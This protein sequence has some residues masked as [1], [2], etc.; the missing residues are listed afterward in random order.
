[1]EAI[2]EALQQEAA[3]T[4]QAIQASFPDEP[5][6]TNA[7][8]G[9]GWWFCDAQGALQYH[10]IGEALDLELFFRGIPQHELYA[11]PPDEYTA[12]FRRLVSTPPPALPWTAFV[13][14]P[15]ITLPGVTA[16]FSFLSP[17]A[18]AYYLPAYLLTAIPGLTAMRLVTLRGENF[19]QHPELSSYLKVIDPTIQRLISPPEVAVWE[20]LRHVPPEVLDPRNRDIRGLSEADYFLRFAGQLTIPQRRAVGRFVAYLL[21]TYPFYT[22]PIHTTEQPLDCETQEEIDALRRCW[23]E[24]T[25]T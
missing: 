19:L 1:M 6:P 11:L 14:E 21:Q 23:V 18:S 4:T 8:I 7:P 2:Q 12:F 20:A 9:R 5:F 16:S 24:P 3:E 22:P 15:L 10:L 13:G 25:W 17:Q